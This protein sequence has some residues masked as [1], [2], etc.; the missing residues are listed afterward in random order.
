LLA[1]D[2]VVRPVPD[3]PANSRAFGRATAGPRGQAAFPQVRKLSLVEVGSHAE[4]AFVVKGLAAAG[5]EQGLL[6]A[7]LQQLPPA[8][9][10]LLDSGFY[11][12]RLWQK[13][14]ATGTAALVRLSSTLKRPVLRQLPDG[15]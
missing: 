14:V 12:Y 8:S 13:V 10:L 11:G 7:L 3:S 9:L 6:P 1:S 15:S 5:G 4:W 2:G